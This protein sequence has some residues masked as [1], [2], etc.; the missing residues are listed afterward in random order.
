MVHSIRKSNPALVSALDAVYCIAKYQDVYR[1]GSS[2]GIWVLVGIA[3]CHGCL[4]EM[5]IYASR[6]SDLPKLQFMTTLGCTKTSL[7]RPNSPQK[8]MFSTGTL[9]RTDPDS[10]RET[11]TFELGSNYHRP[12]PPLQNFLGSH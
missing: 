6:S 5:I 10:V 11:L 4:T 1:I 9:G 2:R 3:L 8:S 7:Q 12:V